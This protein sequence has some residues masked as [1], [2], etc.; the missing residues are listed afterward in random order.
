MNLH[1]TQHLFW[2]SVRFNPPPAEAEELFA[3]SAGLSSLDRIGIYRTMYW[4]RQVDALLDSFPHV[5]RALGERDFVRLAC[6]YLT[7]YPSKQSAL[8]RIGVNFPLYARNHHDI[9]SWV[10]Q[11]AM[12][13]WAAMEALLSADPEV[14]ARG[15]NLSAELF[16]NSHAALVPSLRVLRVSAEA[17]VAYGRPRPARPIGV[18]LHRPRF[19]V[20]HCILLEDEYRALARAAAGQ[21]MSRVC[22]CFADSSHP[23]LRAS[24]VLQSW[25]SRGWIQRFVPS[26]IPTKSLSSH[27]PQVATGRGLDEPS[28]R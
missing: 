14:L 9:P 20:E 21:C 22:E 15:L 5:V 6:G 26:S 3:S 17:W 1:E 27:R 24:E 23:Q 10:A 13:D 8:E 28:E 7:A 2:R 25:L 18:A 19:S 4:H 11:V 12:L 16:P